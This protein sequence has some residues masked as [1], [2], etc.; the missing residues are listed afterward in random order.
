MQKIKQYVSLIAAI[1]LLFGLAL[2]LIPPQHVSAGTQ[3]TDR[4]LTLQAGTTDG[5]SMP[6]G[7]VTHQFDF[8]L[9]DTTHAIGSIKFQYCTTAA[10]VPL[11]IGCVAPTGLSTQNASLSFENGATG[12]TGI[13]K[14]NEDD[15]TSGAFNTIIISRAVAANIS[16]NPTAVTYRFSTVVNPSAAET[17]FVRIST[18]STLD[19][20]G[21]DWESGIVA[22][23]TSTQIN[24]E[25]NMPESLVFCA[26]ATV[27]VNG[28]NVPDCST[29]TTG[30]VFF[31][32]LFSPTDTAQATSQ[33]AASTNASSGYVITVN[34]PTLSSGVSNTI[35][36]VGTA[37]YSKPGTPQFGLNLVLNTDFCGSGCNLG[38]DITAAG[39][40]LYNGQSLT[41]YSTGGANCTIAGCAQFK[42]ADADSVADSNSDASDGQ[43]YTVSYIVNVPGSQPAGTYT[44]TLTYICTPTF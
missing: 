28:G 5:G 10:A 27:G 32:R 19:A 1:S 33:M 9:H 37:D 21:S 13:T 18:Y 38:A 4:R 39:G 7:T 42:F 29:V 35:A 44:T 43:I 22:A 16:T 11:G 2:Q 15:T 25:G 20:T 12:F 17:F 26:G 6:G 8:A 34:G 3:I 40:S 36:A 23:A 24:L 41:D 14:G 31:D 30:D